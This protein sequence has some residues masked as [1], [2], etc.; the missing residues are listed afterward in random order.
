MCGALVV[1]AAT[2]GTSGRMGWC[3]KETT[4][5]WA[6][7]CLHHVPSIHLV[8][9]SI[10][11]LRMGALFS[12]MLGFMPAD[13]LLPLLLLPPQLLGFNPERFGYTCVGRI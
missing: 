6:A 4:V 2:A 1:A 12:C 7:M 3:Y 11:L 13:T 5:C 8:P 10:A 9:I